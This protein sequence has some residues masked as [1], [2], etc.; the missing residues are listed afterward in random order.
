MGILRLGSGGG[1]VIAL[2]FNIVALAT[3]GWIYNNTGSTGLFNYKPNVGP[4][5][6]SE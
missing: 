5:I 6:E 4:T 2:I 3:P 1:L